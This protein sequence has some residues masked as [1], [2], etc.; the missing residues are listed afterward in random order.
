[1]PT[2]GKEG[3][4]APERNLEGIQGEEAKAES[5]GKRRVSENKEPHR[6]R[7]FAAFLFFQGWHNFRF[8]PL[9]REDKKS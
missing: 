2:R 4:K 3:V 7:F 5:L 6:I 1:M 8:F 9:L